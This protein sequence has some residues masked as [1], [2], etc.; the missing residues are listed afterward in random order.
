[1]REKTT[2][3]TARKIVLMTLLLAVV[4][5]ALTASVP[6]AEALIA[7]P[8][9]CGY[10]SDATFTTLVGARGTGCCGEVINWGITTAFKKCDRIY[11]TEQ[12]C[13][14]GPSPI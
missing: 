10:Y 13:P 6:R 4:A 14:N 2:L 8:S 1:M 3:F 9:V 11:C 12:L 5:L 7:G